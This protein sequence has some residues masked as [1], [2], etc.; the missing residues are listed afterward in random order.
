MVHPDLF[1]RGELGQPVVGSLEE[2]LIFQPARPPPTPHIHS[3]KVSPEVNV[4]Y[5]G[6]VTIM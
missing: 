1:L 4:L 2:G 6:H 3:S 5:K